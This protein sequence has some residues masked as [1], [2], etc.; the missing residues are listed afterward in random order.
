MTSD[1]RFALRQLFKAPAFTATVVVTLALSIGACTV[2]FSV[3]DTLLLHPLDNPQPEQ[4]VTLRSKNADSPELFVSIADY[5][6]WKKEAHSFAS[7]AARA[8]GIWTLTGQGEARRMRTMHITA[9]YFDV[10]GVQLPLGRTF[11]P[12]ETRPGG[13]NRVVLLSYALWQN[14]FGG[15]ADVLGRTVQLNEMSFTVVG[16]LPDN[17]D[18]AGGLIGWNDI[19]LPLVHAEN[20]REHREQRALGL[21]VEARLKPGVS[22]AQAQAEMDLICDR[23]A[24]RF[25]D[26]NKGVGASVVP[27]GKVLSGA[28][29]PALWSLLG[30]VGGVLLIA[31]ANVANLLLVRA[32]A[33]QRELSLRSAF[34]AGRFR[35]VRLLLTESLLLSLLGGAAGT[36]LAVFG[37]ELI[38]NL[39]FHSSVGLAQLAL[40]KL[41]PWMLGFTFGLSVMTGLLFGLA[42]AWLAS[43]HDINDGLKQSARGSTESG[44]GARLRSALVVFEIAA[45]LML[46][47]STGLLVRSLVR[48]A[49][50]DAGFDPRPLAYANVS[51][52]GSRYLT[53]HTLD[54]PKAA[55]FAEDVLAR[56]RSLPGVVSAGLT[57]NLPGITVGEA[58]NRLTFSIAG[59]PEV[60]VSERPIAEWNNASS[61]YFQTMGIRLL[62]GRTFNDH[63][64]D[65]SP[66]VAVV[67]E[68]FARQYFP[69]EDPLGRSVRIDLGPRSGWSEIVGVVAD[70]VQAYGWNTSPQVYEPFAQIPV[71]YMHFVVRTAGDPAA[72]S[73]ALKAQIQAVDSNLAVPWAQPMTQTIG[74][75]S[76]LARQRFISQLLVLF[77]GIALVIAVVGIYGVIAYSVSRR[78]HE[79]GIRM[80]LGAD[81][82]AVLRLVLSQGAR[83]VGLG[84]LLGIAGAVAGGRAIESMLYRTSAYDPL[85]LAAVTLLF[86]TIAALACWLPARRAT[87]VDPITA[88]RAE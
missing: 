62:R 25:P 6:D 5:L 68:T 16:V 45:S 20:Q 13:N 30:A 42:P 40:V 72:V 86:A 70:T 7:M 2:I 37:I 14:S 53:N 8:G 64:N 18:R 44:T 31:C 59:R 21:T 79:I 83:I 52:Q 82:T 47:A 87:K 61:D 56:L 22:V 80:A 63:D 29:R 73:A 60:P 74:S 24:Q 57:L 10:L 3:V 43:R 81:K 49:N 58:G 54:F 77:S 76:T 11:L 51:L 69:N 65:R 75:I 39:R 15:T 66:R 17:F 33:R 4:R 1:L 55:S 46:I 41:D 48:L 88:L 84:L 36:L 67:S 23:L 78:T 71:G 85:T 28:I 34:G 32:T 50:F 19:A 38:G 35:L 27:T 9:D 26:T 12:E